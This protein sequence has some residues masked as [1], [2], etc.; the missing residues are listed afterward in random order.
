MVNSF[1]YR[2]ALVTITIL[3]DMSYSKIIQAG[4]EDWVGT[5]WIQLYPNQ[6][7]EYCEFRV[8]FLD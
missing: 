2:P 7:L 5:N 6:I 8:L 1:Q 3:N 4:Y